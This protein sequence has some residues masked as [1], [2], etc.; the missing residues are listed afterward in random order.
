[1][2]SAENWRPSLTQYYGLL[3]SKPTNDYIPGIRRTWRFGFASTIGKDGSSKGH[4]RTPTK[5]RDQARRKKS[6]ITLSFSS[7]KYTYQ[8]HSLKSFPLTS[9]S[10]SCGLQQGIFI[11]TYTYRTSFSDKLFERSF[12][13][14]QV[15]L[16]SWRDEYSY[17]YIYIYSLKL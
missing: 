7:K 2:A 4:R 5:P 12:I 10:A 9:A 13:L 6:W 8:T 1:M 17:S 3:R 14:P 15:L 16:A 11:D